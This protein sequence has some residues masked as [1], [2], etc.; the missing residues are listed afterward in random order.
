MLTIPPPR[1]A[2]RMCPRSLSLK[3]RPRS[4][5]ATF[6]FSPSEVCLHG[7]CSGLE[8][9]EADSKDCAFLSE[10]WDPWRQ[11]LPKC[12]PRPAGSS[13]PRPFKMRVLWPAHPTGPRARP[14]VRYR[15]A[16]QD[17]PLVSWERKSGHLPWGVRA[18]A[19]WG[20]W[21]RCGLRVPLPCTHPGRPA[22]LAAVSILRAGA[23][24]SPTLPPSSSPGDKL[25]LPGG[26][27]LCAAA[28]G[29][30]CDT[31]CRAL[32]CNL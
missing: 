14:W 24:T 27:S 11:W 32:Y 16:G 7:F 10:A 6:R 1:A 9:S 28:F 31:A 3:P 30:T 21:E 22:C 8:F 19:V 23:Q 29:H 17:L 18:R 15:D 4:P 13:S 20:K 2:P 12:G 5:W 25:E 26:L